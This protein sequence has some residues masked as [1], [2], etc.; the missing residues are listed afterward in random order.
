MR[1]IITK[2]YNEKKTI[3]KNKNTKESYK[4][5]SKRIRKKGKTCPSNHQALPEEAFIYKTLAKDW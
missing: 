1:E 5:G 4:N 3:G 2:N